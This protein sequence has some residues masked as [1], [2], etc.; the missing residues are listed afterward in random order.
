MAPRSAE[1]A[2]AP[3]TAARVL[4]LD[5]VRGAA[6]MFVVLHHIWLTTWPRFP[7][8]AGPWWLGWLLYGHMAVAIFIVVSGFSLSLAPMRK[9]GNLSGG[10][11]RFLQRRAW[12]ILPAYWAALILSVLVT[13]LLLHPEF[14]AATMGKS[15]AVHGLLLQDVVG[16]QTPNGALWS[17]AIEWQIY[18][19]FPLILLLG[20][21][22][23]VVTAVVI[24]AVA[25]LLAHAVAG[26]GG[27]FHKI[28]G[29]TPQFLAL[30]ALG[31][32]AV[33]LAGGDRAQ[34]LRRPLAAVTLV[35]FAS[36]L[37]L[38]ITQGSEWMVAQVFWMD[39]LFG[40]GVAALLALIHAGGAF[41]A[42]RVL[43][44]R[45][46]LWLGLFSYSIYLIHDPI[47]GVLDKYVFGPMDLSALATFGL[48]LVLGLPVILALCYGFHLL[49]EAPF[50]RRRDLSALRTLPIVQFWS[51]KRVSSPAPS[52]AD[53]TPIVPK[54]Q[55]AAG[56]RASG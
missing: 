15:L 53:G 50:L 10:V 48:T 46:A 54:P 22:T 32:L 26:F 34:T 38:A 55:P 9:G 43:A 29:F 45:V 4:W 14:G 3:G 27:P 56:E 52:P 20:R 49:F 39:L 44:S 25:V 47:I 28:Y 35:A 41:P 1:V 13:A 8:N 42:R 11:K 18:F 40:V 51:R 24:T 16:S 23:T 12:R 30:F 31:A 2:S 21:R 36:F 5:G 6:A 17:I 7:A 37:I 33:W 19:V